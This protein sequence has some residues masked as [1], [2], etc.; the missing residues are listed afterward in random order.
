MIRNIIILSCS[1]L[2]LFSCSITNDE[3]TMILKG[4]VKDLKKGTI[5]LERFVDSAYVAIDSSVIYGDSNFEFKKQLEN[6]EVLHL[7]LRLENGS[8]IE[9]RVSF[10]A[11]P[12][13]IN[14]YTKRSEEHT[15]ELQ[16]R[17][18]LVCRLLLEKKTIRRSND[19]D[20]RRDIT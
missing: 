18:H 20:L 12:G 7:H 1:L 2:F 9:D 3:N 14:L 17:G 4:K 19:P 15:S 8:L 6:P 11:E 13:E 10:F 16:S 5:L